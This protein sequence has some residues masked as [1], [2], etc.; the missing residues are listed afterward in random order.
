MSTTFCY[1]YEYSCCSFPASLF[2]VMWRNRAEL[3]QDGSEKRDEL[4]PLVEA[5]KL[6]CWYW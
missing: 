3:A 2:F 6:D 4:A 5:Y 1:W